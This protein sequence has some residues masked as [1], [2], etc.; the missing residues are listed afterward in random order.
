MTRKCCIVIFFSALLLVA[1]RPGSVAFAASQN[2]KLSPEEAALAKRL[3][4]NPNPLIP[5]FRYRSVADQ[6][7]LSPWVV[8]GTVERIDED[9]YGPYHTK[10]RVQV[11]RYLK[12]EGPRE[13]TL[14]ILDGRF[15]SEYY[16]K[17]M[18]AN[19]VGGLTFS[20][21]DFEGRFILFLDKYAMS[22]RGRESQY[23][24]GEG[25]FRTANRYR[26]VDDHAEPDP[27]MTEAG[28]PDAKRYSYQGIVAEILRVA[29][30]QSQ[31]SKGTP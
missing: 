31:L 27:G 17:I 14:N 13:I 3:G 8:E 16:K 6:T 24:H 12:G 1:P 21:E 22:P 18:R 28:R 2:E 25:E 9:L 4:V 15:Y 20:S 10:V 23:T 5:Q 30:P 19:T 26:V 11:R 29:V 7:W